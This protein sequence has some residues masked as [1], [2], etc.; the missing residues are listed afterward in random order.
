MI[1]LNIILLQCGD[2]EQNPGPYTTFISG[3]LAGLATALAN[4]SDGNVYFKKSGNVITGHTSEN[5][6]VLV[7]QGFPYAF[8]DGSVVYLQHGSIASSQDIPWLYPYTILTAV[9]SNLWNNKLC[10][11][12]DAKESRAINANDE[13]VISKDY[14]NNYP[15]IENTSQ[16]KIVYTNNTLDMTNQSMLE[17]NSTL[18]VEPYFK[19]AMVV[20]IPTQAVTNKYIFKHN[21][22]E[23]K[24]S[25]ETAADTTTQYMI[26]AFD[27]GT[28]LKGVTFKP[29]DT[30]FKYFIYFDN[31]SALSVSSNDAAGGSNGSFVG[32]TTAKVYINE[33]ASQGIGNA[34][35]KLYELLY[36]NSASNDIAATKTNMWDYMSSVN[37][38]NLSTYTADHNVVPP[39][40]ITFTWDNTQYGYGDR[41]TRI[42]ISLINLSIA[43]NIQNM[44]DGYESNTGSAPYLSPGQ[45]LDPSK[46]I[47]FTLNTAQIICGIKWFKSD[48]DTSV[49]Q[50]FHF[51]GSNDNSSWNAIQNS[52]QFGRS[53]GT[54]ITSGQNIPDYTNNTA[55]GNC[56]VYSY[57]FTNTTAYKYYRLWGS[58]GSTSGS[59]YDTE[60][61]FKIGI[62]A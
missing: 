47:L 13:K 28:F 23:I 56:Y 11:W 32:G 61:N 31:A 40:P 8:V 35:I 55:S 49:D 20:E 33:S 16:F 38:W 21:D 9:S 57:E 42:T 24:I 29:S 44:V 52:L 51:Q 27:N 26:C 19:L 15:L 17:T 14:T 2:I 25:Q 12:I 46:W 45:S 62:P 7:N 4:A 50:Y 6:H 59:P 58:S 34:K 60:F 37:R 54:A 48:P 41:R 10:L 5:S 39:P 22:L 30:S 1:N 18:T 3:E 36:Y 53:V 43:G